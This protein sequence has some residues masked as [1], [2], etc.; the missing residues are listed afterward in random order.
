MDPGAGPSSAPP[1]DEEEADDGDGV[2]ERS[3]HRVQRG[4]GIGAAFEALR[5][6]KAVA[7][8]RHAAIP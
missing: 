2:A 8:A 6:A 5:E 3:G 4:G 1:D 7:E